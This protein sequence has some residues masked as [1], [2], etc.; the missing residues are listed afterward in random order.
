M[1][2]SHPLTLFGEPWYGSA[3]FH[4]TPGFWNYIYMVLSGHPFYCKKISGR[5]KQVFSQLK[6][7]TQT[8][9]LV[10]MFSYY[11]IQHRKENSFLQLESRE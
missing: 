3:R 10:V 6:C 4:Q 1:S 9:Q 5:L 7:C 8:W 2:H 11:K